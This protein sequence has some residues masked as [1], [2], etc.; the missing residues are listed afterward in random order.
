MTRRRR[1]A[2]D[3]PGVERIKEAFAASATRAARLGF[4]ALELHCAHGYLLHEFLSP[5]ANRREDQFGG[6]LKNRMRFPLEV[7]DAIRAVWPV[8]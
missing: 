7:F 2:L 5:I 3:I 6:A 4:D 1:R 8:R